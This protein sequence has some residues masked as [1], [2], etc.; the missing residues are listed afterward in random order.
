MEYRTLLMFVFS[1]NIT[2]NC[3]VIFACVAYQYSKIRRIVFHF[4]ICKA[5]Y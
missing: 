5:L 1:I 4:S 3:K 2:G